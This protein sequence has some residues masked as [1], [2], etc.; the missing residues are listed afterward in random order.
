MIMP[1][2]CEGFKGLSL[3][4]GLVKEVEDFVESSKGYR[5]VAEFVSEATRLRLEELR[6]KPLRKEA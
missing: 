2:K 6:K 3:K 4:A 1:S 5:S